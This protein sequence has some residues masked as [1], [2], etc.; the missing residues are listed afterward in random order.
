MITNSECRKV[1]RG[2]PQPVAPEVTTAV[3]REAVVH[4]FLPPTV[5]SEPSHTLLFKT[6]MVNYPYSVR[7]TNTGGTLREQYC[8]SN[9]VDE[10]IDEATFNAVQKEKRRRSNYEITE[11]GKRRKA[12]KY[13]SAQKEA[14]NEPDNLSTQSSVPD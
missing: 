8:M 2:K 7:R 13:S 3:D 4:R 6:V 14:E 5:G 9:G 11:D 1:R 12:K 10:I